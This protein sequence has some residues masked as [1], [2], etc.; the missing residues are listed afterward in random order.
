LACG[1]QVTDRVSCNESKGSSI[2]SRGGGWKE[3]SR[4]ARLHGRSAS[5]GGE[6]RRVSLSQSQSQ[7]RHASDSQSKA[8][9]QEAGGWQKP[10]PADRDRSEKR[11]RENREARASG[12]EKRKQSRQATGLTGMLMVESRREMRALVIVIIIV[13]L[14]IFRFGTLSSYGPNHRHWSVL[15]QSLPRKHL[16]WSIPANYS[17]CDHQPASSA[18]E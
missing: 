13:I 3:D 10:A 8:L 18:A 16:L 2:R 6:R 15:V 4:G 11:G 1:C 14:A 5:M 12:S 17:R 9:S 7:S